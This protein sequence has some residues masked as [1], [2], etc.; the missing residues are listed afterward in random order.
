MKKA[1]QNLAVLACDG[2]F[3]TVISGERPFQC[4]HTILD[5]Q[6]YE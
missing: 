4:D 5:T 3:C 1:A 6:K 2:P